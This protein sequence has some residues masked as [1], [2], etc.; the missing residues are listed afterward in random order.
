[1]S[2]ESD[3][4][5]PTW[6]LGAIANGGLKRREWCLCCG[7]RKATNGGPLCETCRA[8]RHCEMRFLGGWQHMGGV[9]P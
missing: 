1:M 4:W 3:S 9:G 6:I 5:W 7:G 8:S 2:D